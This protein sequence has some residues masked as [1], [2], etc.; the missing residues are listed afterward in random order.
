MTAHDSNGNH[1]HL[2]IHPH[3]RKTKGQRITKKTLHL[4]T[5]ITLVVALILASMSLYYMWWNYKKRW[6]MQENACNI[7]DPPVSKNIVRLRAIFRSD[8]NN[9]K[10]KHKTSLGFSWKKLYPPVEDFLKLTHLDFQSNL[11][12]PLCNFP[13]FALPPYSRKS[14]F[15]PPFLV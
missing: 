2:L 6:R 8:H 14:M 1:T 11:P 4:I 5:T 10:K 15:F 13:F 9:W 7:N 3:L 12:V